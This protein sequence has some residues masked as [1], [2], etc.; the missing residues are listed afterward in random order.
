[1]NIAPLHCQ[2]SNILKTQSHEFKRGGAA[3][4]QASGPYPSPY[5]ILRPPEPEP[6]A[7]HPRRQPVPEVPASGLSLNEGGAAVAA[8]PTS[9]TGPVPAVFLLTR[10]LLHPPRAPL[11][12]LA[13]TAVH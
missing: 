6:P 4:I 8:C 11:V 12:P 7:C 5:P 9:Q 13:A 10:L 2:S 1:M 3:P